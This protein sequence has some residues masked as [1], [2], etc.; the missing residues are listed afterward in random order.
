MQEYLQATSF[1]DF[2]HPLI[3]QFAQQFE[4]ESY[5]SDKA[6]AIDLYYAVRDSIAYNPYVFTFEPDTLSASYCLKNKESY[7][8]PKAVLL[9]A[10]ARKF[11]IPSRIGLSDVKNHLSS[12]KLLDILRS[13]VFVMHG[14]VELYLDGLWVK[15]TPAFDANLCEKIQVEPLPFDGEEDSLFQEYNSQGQ[16][17]MEYVK[18]H[19]TFA[20]VPMEFIAQSVM[21][22]YP[23]LM[24]ESMQRAY[25]GQSLKEEI[26]AEQEK[27]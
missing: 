21:H 27:Q 26:Q 15:A 9:G 10:L 13:D 24:S 2:Q 7:C 19:G 20:D 18:E 5:S 3:E 12:Q 1:F 4:L 8:I 23:H 25:H 6:L 16:K 11:G 22:A 17:H 14:Y